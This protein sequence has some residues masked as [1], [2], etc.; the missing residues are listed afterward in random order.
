M[1]RGQVYFELVFF[2][3]ARSESSLS[4]YLERS[5]DTTPAASLRGRNHRSRTIQSRTD[6]TQ[7]TDTTN[8]HTYIKI[9]K[10]TV[11][12]KTERTSWL[13]VGSLG[14]CLVHAKSGLVLR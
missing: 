11:L 10:D 13:P 4:G 3:T 8:K 14:I 6:S 7:R 9:Y 1:D 2:Q 12:A 5:K